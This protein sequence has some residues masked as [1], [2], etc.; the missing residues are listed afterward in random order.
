VTIYAHHLRDELS[1]TLAGAGFYPATEEDIPFIVALE[2]EPHAI[3]TISGY[4][5][6]MH[7]N[8]MLSEDALYG[9]IF[10]EMRRPS[11]FAILCGLAGNH[12]SIELRRIYLRQSRVGIGRKIL[13]AL[14]AATVSCGLSNRLWLD[15]F[16]DNLIARTFYQSLGFKEEGR[17][18]DAA[19]REGEYIS[20]ILMSIIASDFASEIQAAP[21]DLSEGMS[22]QA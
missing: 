3:A 20:L 13:L 6:E 1:V 10:D 16:E 11:G 17:L 2:N 15:V 19:I 14:I 8:L 7:L 12:R 5:R 18:R 4:S 22:L 21:V 9:I